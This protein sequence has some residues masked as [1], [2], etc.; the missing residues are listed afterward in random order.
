MSIVQ[1]KHG[2]MFDG[3]SDLIVL[4][5]S[6]GGTITPFVRQRL[7]HYKIPYPRPGMKL[8]D[9][10]IMPFEGGENIAQYVAYAASVDAELSSLGSS[11]PTWAIRR[12]GAQLGS[13]TR[14]QSTIRLVSAPLLGTGAGDLNP[15]QVV[16][17]LSSGFKSEAH[18]EARMAIHVLEEAVF[19]RL[20]RPERVRKSKPEP[21]GQDKALR[22]FISYSH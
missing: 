19:E 2:D 22:V 20:S 6:T 5:C 8:G 15:R 18:S 21:T 3:P 9:V 7:V 17:S 10:S 13:A 1:L 12:I 14:N 16:Q 11:T 4:P